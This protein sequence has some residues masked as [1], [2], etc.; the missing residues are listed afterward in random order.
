MADTEPDENDKRELN[1]TTLSQEEWF[2]ELNKCDP[3]EQYARKRQQQKSS[4]KEQ[5]KSGEEKQEESSEERRE[6]PQEGTTL[7]QE[8]WFEELSKHDSFDQYAKRR[9]ERREEE[10]DDE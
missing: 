7:S 3:L 6:E 5:E 9:R 10:A 4:E 1:T 8:E 2:E